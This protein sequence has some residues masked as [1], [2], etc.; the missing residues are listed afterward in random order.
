MR[1]DVA[2]SILAAYERETGWEHEFDDG[3]PV[4]VVTP[5]YRDHVID[6]MLDELGVQV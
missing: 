5:Q 1:A 4:P 6:Q 3:Y 2:Q